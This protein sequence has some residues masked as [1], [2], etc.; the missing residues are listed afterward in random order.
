[1]LVTVQQ[2]YLFLL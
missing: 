1:M 2:F